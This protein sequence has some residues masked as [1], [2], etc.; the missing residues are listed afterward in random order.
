M[1]IKGVKVDAGLIKVEK[2]I[3]LAEKM[4]FWDVLFQAKLIKQCV[5]LS[6]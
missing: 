6:R 3:D 1:A 2:L 5:L 4:I